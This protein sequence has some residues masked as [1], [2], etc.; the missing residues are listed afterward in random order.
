ML[1]PEPLNAV[2]SP[3]R[4]DAPHSTRV[5]GTENGSL[6]SGKCE[7]RTASPGR[8]YVTAAQDMLYDTL[9]GASNVYA[10]ADVQ[11]KEQAR[12]RQR[13]L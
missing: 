4:S 5:S 13:E 1:H 6:L 2:T 8:R 3:S 11:G 10:E 9:P 7:G 12:K